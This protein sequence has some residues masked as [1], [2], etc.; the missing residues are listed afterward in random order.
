MGRES[1]GFSWGGVAAWIKVSPRGR[2]KCS[3]ERSRCGERAPQ[4]RQILA[5]GNLQG[6][7]LARMLGEELGVEEQVAALAQ[8]FHEIRQG[9]LGS[10]AHAREH[11]FAGKETCQ[12]HAVDAA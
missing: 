11:R 3:D 12:G 7:E 1:T 5:A 2:V 4:A 10:I 6:A 8:S 9:D